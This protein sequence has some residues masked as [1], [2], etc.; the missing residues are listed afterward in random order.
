MP[1]FSRGRSSRLVLVVGCLA[2]LASA[3]APAEASFRWCRKDPIVELDGRQVNIYIIA[4]QGIQNRAN[5]PTRVIVSHPKG[6]RSVHRDD[7]DDKDFAGG[8]WKVDFRPDPKLEVMPNDDIPFQVDVR[9][10]AREE[11]RVQVRL[12]IPEDEGLE[13]IEPGWTREWLSV[14]GTV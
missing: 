5:G 3:A 6:V 12:K 4:E 9:V 2:L 1:G 11:M 7:L 10:P 8:E 14:E 13:D